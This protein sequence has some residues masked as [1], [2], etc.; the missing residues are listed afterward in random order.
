MPG[1]PLPDPYKRPPTIDPSDPLKPI[2]PPVEEPDPDD[3]DNDRPK[4]NPDEIEPEKRV[5]LL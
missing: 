5:L 3:P 1:S 4:P 2:I